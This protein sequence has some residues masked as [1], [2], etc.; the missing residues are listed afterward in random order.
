[1]APILFRFSI[2]WF[3]NVQDHSYSYCYNRPFQNRTIGNLNLKTFGF[4]MCSVFQCLGYSS[5]HC[6]L[7]EFKLKPITIPQLTASQIHQKSSVEV[8]V[9]DERCVNPR[10]A[11]MVDTKV[12]HLSVSTEQVASF[13]VN[14]QFLN[15]FRLLHHVQ[16]EAGRRFASPKTKKTLICQP[17]N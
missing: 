9:I 4:P 13:I 17:Q 15:Q 7:V 5:P 11:G 1:M 12:G 10:A 8:L 6:I 3:L 16:M 14:H 2:V